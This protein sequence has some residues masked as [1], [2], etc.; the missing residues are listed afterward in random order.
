MML[1]NLLLFVLPTLSLSFM[2]QSAPR[3]ETALFD[4]DGTGGWGIGSSRELT[5]EE[6]ARSDRAYFDGYKMSEQGDFRRQIADDKES[7]K[8]QEL[9]ELL[10]V[11]AIAGIKVKN[12]SERLNKFEDAGFAADDDED[13]DLSI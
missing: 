9:E 2:T 1:S 5:P 13:L 8:Q 12:P 11:A 10:G 6:F 3:V 7:L 4:G